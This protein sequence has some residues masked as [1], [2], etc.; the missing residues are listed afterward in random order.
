[1]NNHYLAAKEDRL[2]QCGL[3]RPKI[4]YIT[5]VALALESGQLTPSTWSSMSD[6]EI[7]KQLMSVSGIGKWTAQ[8]FLIFHLNRADIFP[9]TD[10]GLLKAIGLQ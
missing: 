9:Q 4:R 3:S 8:I 6:D 7:A 2:R 10:V 5:N 1:L